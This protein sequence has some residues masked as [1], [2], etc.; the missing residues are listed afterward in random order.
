MFAEIQAK[1]LLFEMVYRQYSNSDTDE[2]EHGNRIR[3]DT[4]IQIVIPMNQYIFIVVKIYGDGR[5]VNR[6]DEVTL[7]P[8]KKQADL[9]NRV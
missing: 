2:S 9:I 6:N 1:W 7:T 5:G 8:L 3:I 4:G